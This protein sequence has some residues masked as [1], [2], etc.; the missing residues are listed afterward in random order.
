MMLIRKGVFMEVKMQFQKTRKI[1]E[2]EPANSV[3]VE[4]RGS[5]VLVE[6]LKKLIVDFMEKQEGFEQHY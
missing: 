1:Y 2:A 3:A 6:I 4:L 5:P